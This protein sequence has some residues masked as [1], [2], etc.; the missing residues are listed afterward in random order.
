MYARPIQ[1]Q[2]KVHSK[3]LEFLV[4]TYD[5]GFLRCAIDVVQTVVL[6]F[7]CLSNF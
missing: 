5:M 7:L 1:I 6:Y 3:I 2:T 4:V